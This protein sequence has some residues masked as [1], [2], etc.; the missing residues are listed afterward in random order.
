MKIAIDAWGG[1]FAPW[2][3]LQGIKSAFHP[4]YT[5]VVVGSREKLLSLYRE[6][7]MDERN[8]PIEEASQVIG[9]QEH[10][11]DAVRKK[12]DSTI[13]KGVKLLARKEVD[14]FIS[15]GNSGAV[16]AS[17]WLNL[18]GLAEIERPAIT[19]LIPNVHSYTVL[20]DVGANVDCKPKHLLHFGIMG[21][22][23]AKIVLGV[24]SPRVGLLSIGEEEGKGNELVK[25]AYQLLK[26]RKNLLNFE[27]V[28]NVEGHNIVD[29]KVDVVVCDGFTGNALLKFGEGLIEF[30][31]SSLSQE[32]QEQ[33][34]M[35]K[36]NAFWRKLDRSEYGGAPLLGI[37]GVC[38][39]CH[40]KSRA[41][42][43]RSAVFRAKELVE[44]GILEKIKERLS[45]LGLER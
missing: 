38:L 33:D 32:I 40:G 15:A 8:F 43:I 34:F 19:A 42:D 27:F 44:K 26:E 31:A 30:I 28:G 18:K 10:P 7:D 3:I 12:P 1:D 11:A 25:M 16:M 29:G 5:L 23:Y 2:E 17:A 6:L 35:E 21:A 22:E 36:L 24:P 4:G 20:L 37:E 14:A 13:C 9:M 41:K 39:V 45:K